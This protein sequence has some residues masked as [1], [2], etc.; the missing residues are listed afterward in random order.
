MGHTRRITLNIDET[1]LEQARQ[2]T[3]GTQ[4]DTVHEALQAL[5]RERALDRLAGRGGSVPNF[6]PAPRKRLLE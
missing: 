2:E 5:L 1:L 6:E 3:R 4:T